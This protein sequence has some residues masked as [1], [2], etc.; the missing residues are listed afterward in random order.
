MTLDK[1]DTARAII[2][3]PSGDDVLENNE[4]DSSTASSSSN[5]SSSCTSS[6]SSSS[7]GSSSSGSTSS[8][9]SASSRQSQVHVHVQLQKDE[10]VDR[11]EI[12]E[13]IS[14]LAST[15]ETGDNWGVI[16]H[17]ASNGVLEETESLPNTDF[18]T[19]RDC[20]S[21]TSASKSS[22]S[23]NN[24][25]SSSNESGG[26]ANICD[27]GCRIQSQVQAEVHINTDELKE[28]ASCTP[29]VIKSANDESSLTIAI[30]PCV[31]QKE[32]KDSDC[33]SSTTSSKSSSSSSSASSSK[34]AS[35]SAS[36]SSASSS[37]T[38]LASSSPSVN[39]S[40]PT[41]QQAVTMFSKRS[42]L[43]SPDREIII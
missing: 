1:I 24:R 12:P 21:G 16:L 13:R 10:A 14:V 3:L 43:L 7:S 42:P 37:S 29:E 18:S 26:P 20:R 5:G 39:A 6:S 23:I 30:E 41:E 15:S 32:D 34:S 38:S 2:V 33:S 19:S 11:L 9:A 28:A 31:T 22:R 35:S 25:K 36:S 4:S 8:S 40:N 27:S 17:Q